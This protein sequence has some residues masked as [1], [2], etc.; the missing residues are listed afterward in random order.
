MG[1]MK[2]IP[3]NPVLLPVA[4]GVPQFRAAKRPDSAAL[5]ACL[6][7]LP[8]A[9]SRAMKRS[10]HA[11]IHIIQAL[12]AAFLMLAAGA[13]SGQQST[14]P[15]PLAATAT[16][17]GPLEI[18][19]VIERAQAPTEESD[20]GWSFEPA[21]RLT[22]GDQVQ[23]TLRVTN[24]GKEPVSDVVVTKL[25]P[26]GFVYVGG[27]AAGPASRVEFSADGGKSFAP[28][29]EVMLVRPGQ[30]PREATPEEYSHVRWILSRPVPPRATALLRFRAIFR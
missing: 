26:T 25:F 12:A 20:A 3:G 27:S 1:L 28:A 10:G 13:S 7:G 5:R 16:G 30:T 8:D 21:D 17:S 15:E 4:S 11:Q 18:V 6:G 14:P 24:P 9:Q 22:T 29:A 23:Y 2:A 19:T